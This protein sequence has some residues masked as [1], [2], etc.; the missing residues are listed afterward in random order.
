MRRDA[1][2]EGFGKAVVLGCVRLVMLFEEASRRFG[3]L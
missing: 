3:A 2:S 1:G